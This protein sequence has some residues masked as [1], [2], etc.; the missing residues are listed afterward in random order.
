VGPPV[1]RGA[2]PEPLVGGVRVGLRGLEPLVRRLPGRRGGIRRVVRLEVRPVERLGDRPYRLGPEAQRLALVR[3]H[4]LDVAGARVQG[5][6]GD[7]LAELP[8]PGDQAATGE[9]DVVGVRGDEDMGHGRPSIRRPRTVR[10]LSCADLK[11]NS[12]G[13][14]SVAARPPPTAPDRLDRAT[15]SKQRRRPATLAVQHER[16]HCDGQPVMP[17]VVGR[18]TIA[19]PTAVCSQQPRSVSTTRQCHHRTTEGRRY[20]AGGMGRARSAQCQA[21]RVGWPPPDTT[22][23]DPVGWPD[24]DRE[25]GEER[26]PGERPPSTLDE[27]HHGE[28]PRQRPRDDRQ[29]KA[30][31]GQPVAPRAKGEQQAGQREQVHL[32]HPQ[33]APQVHEGER[34]HRG[35]GDQR[36]A[37]HKTGRDP[38]HDQARRRPQQP[39]DIG[40][41]G[42]E[43]GQHVGAKGGD[44]K[45]CPSPRRCR[46]S[47]SR[48]RVAAAAWSRAAARLS[49][50]SKARGR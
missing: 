5:Q 28:R 2:L 33:R 29:R 17:R 36:V 14:G 38:E 49:S 30:E 23:S 41:Q 20:H 1:P 9:C 39:H 7:R 47:E 4:A 3:R 27:Q 22:G 24:Q 13:S 31:P 46:R 25:A 44:T 8:Q 21:G 35:A 50:M 45:T 16:R 11:P 18:G 34:E 6:D 15:G 42:R 43:R 12:Q 10:G 32:A 40:G 37:S 48:V 26:R 19:S